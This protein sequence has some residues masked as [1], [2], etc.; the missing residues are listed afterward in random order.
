[1]T[2]GII[3][4]LCGS[5]SGGGG[6]SSL[7]MPFSAK[8]ADFTVDTSSH[9]YTITAIDPATITVTLPLASTCPNILFILDGSPST[10]VVNVVPSGSDTINTNPGSFNL[11]RSLFYSDGISNFI[12]I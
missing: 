10:G 6:S 3:A 12:A 2:A 1:M 11:V 7:T 5:S 8:S 9:A 4:A